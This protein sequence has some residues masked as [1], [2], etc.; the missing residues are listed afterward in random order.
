[1]FGDEDV[2][3]PMVVSPLAARS[4]TT[5]DRSSAELSASKPQARI[6][7]G[8]VTRPCGPGFRWVEQD[9]HHGDQLPAGK[10]ITSDCPPHGR[11]LPPLSSQECLN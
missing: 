10:K 8:P 2:M 5:L 3:G 11:L 9:G 6:L 1:V 7:R 4:S